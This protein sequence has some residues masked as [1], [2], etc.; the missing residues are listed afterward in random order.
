MGA[1]FVSFSSLEF[2]GW[3]VFLYDFDKY[4]QWYIFFLF[5]YIFCRI[6]LSVMMIGGCRFYS[7]INLDMSIKGCAS[8]FY[9]KLI[10]KVGSIVYFFFVSNGI[11]NR[12]NWLL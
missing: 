4:L 2:I 3:C 5:R 7:E 12:R 11:I 1:E 8:K 9:Q 10:I 6:V